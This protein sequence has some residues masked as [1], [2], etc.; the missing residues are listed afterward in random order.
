MS[1]DAARMAY[2]D[3]SFHEAAHGGFYVL[4]AAVFDESV[5]DTVRTA[6]QTLRGKRQT[7]KLHWNEMDTRQRTTAA[8]AVAALDGFHIVAIGTPVP[9]T[10]QERA[11][12]M[13]LTR[14]VTELHSF[15]VSDLVIESRTRQLDAR[16]IATVRGARFLLPKG[17]R[18]HVV[19][20][21][22]KQEPLLWPADLVAGAVRA[23]RQG[24]ATFRRQLEHCLYEVEL[25]THS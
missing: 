15:S 25:D 7:P 9:R 17:S 16:D 13:C 20:V 12:A 10:R 23:H 4:A 8:A 24:D 18:F 1:N 14:L 11:R 21:P 5:H 6:M 22:G 2:A 3:E 19:H